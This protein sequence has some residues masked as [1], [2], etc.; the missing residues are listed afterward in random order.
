[1]SFQVGRVS[2]APYLY[3]MHQHTAGCSAC[4][5]ADPVKTV[6]ALKAAGFTGM[7]L[8][9]HFFRGNTGINRRLEWVDFVR[10]YIAAYEVAKAAGEKLDFDV[11]FGL[12]EGVGG[13]KE[14]LLYGITPAWVLAH[15]Q[16]RELHGDRESLERLCAMVHEG[17]GLVYQAHPFRVREYIADPWKP[18]PPEFLD[19]VEGYN[20]C[21]SP[22]ENA[23]AVAFAREFDL[24]LVAGSDSHVADFRGRYGI[25]CYHR[26]RTGQELAETL[27]EQDYELYIPD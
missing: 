6:K 24:P 19:G 18:L 14:V 25:A 21:N 16:L 5:G 11:L 8:T 9:N 4:A 1:M 23:R 7:V 27:L 2:G 12:E 13:G 15:P 26:I 10:P 20:A 17:G 22:V 3:E